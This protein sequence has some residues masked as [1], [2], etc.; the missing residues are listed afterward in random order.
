MHVLG[1]F[2][3]HLRRHLL[4]TLSVHIQRPTNKIVRDESKEIWGMTLTWGCPMKKREVWGL[5][6][7]WRS[8]T[9]KVQSSC[10][11]P[12]PL[13]L[14]NTPPP[15]ARQPSGLSC[16]PFC[17]QPHRQTRL[18]RPSSVQSRSALRAH[19]S[20]AGALWIIV[21]SRLVMLYLNE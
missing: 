13:P 21:I 15:P 12:K 11:G 17:S 8:D 16:C 1:F 9:C 3:Y 19:P 5:Q 18:Q 7:R 14:W 2:Q 10:T 6:N 4:K 20:L